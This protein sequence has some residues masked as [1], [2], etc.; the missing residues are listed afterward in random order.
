MGSNLLDMSCI[1]LTYRSYTYKG[2]CIE[3]TLASIMQQEDPPLEV[4]IV[5]NSAS[6]SDR[7]KLHKFLAE[8][9]FSVPTKVVETSLGRSSARNEGIKRS[10][11]KTLVFVD[12]D[13][14][15]LT[16]HALRLI[17][18]YVKLNEYGCGASRL[19]TH[20]EGW[21]EGSSPKIFDDIRKGELKL[22]RDH[23]DLPYNTKR[24]DS[25]EDEQVNI[26]LTRSYIANF[27]F[28][29]RSAIT[30]VDGFRKSFDEHW[31]FEDAALMVDLFVLYGRPII[32]NA[33]EVAHVNH[34]QYGGDVPSFKSN[35][36]LYRE[37]LD[38]YGIDM[39][40]LRSL[41][42]PDVFP[43]LELFRMKE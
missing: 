5:E 6:R 36:S 38:D 7:I 30:K 31:G 23:L 43:G 22:L 4:V 21:F 15:L 17:D 29:S 39:L 28:V 27:G 32:L 12:D 26:H 37:L 42:F 9:R 3:H 13:T 24:W 40:S 34:A 25:G 2:G 35:L 14:I 19:W 8:M 10:K 1:V 18:E 11:G 20:P 33:I 16:P 41:V